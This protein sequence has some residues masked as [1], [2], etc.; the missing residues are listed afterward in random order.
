MKLQDAASILGLEGN[1]DAEM[2]RKAWVAAAKKY[3]PDVNSAGLEM[4]KVI[5]AAYERLKGFVG[6]LGSIHK[7]ESGRS[8]PD[9]LN[10]ALNVIIATPLEI[11]ICG[12]WV[13]VG[14]DT[15]AYRDVLKGA[16][17]R[18]AP[19]K[20][21]WY[22]RPAEWKSR[23]RGKYTMDDIR[24]FHGSYSPRK[25]KTIDDEVKV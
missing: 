18:W 23:S 21:R 1:V 8:Y 17:Y 5:N 11:E 13:W 12:A 4:M 20:K 2:V 7:A 6:T 15:R 25:G 16:G 19:N 10:D 9:F 24:G 14:G 3:H 22:F